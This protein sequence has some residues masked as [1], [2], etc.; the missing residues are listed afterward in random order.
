MDIET[1]PYRK[2]VTAYIVNN[3][4]EFIIVFS[5]QPGRFCKTPAGGVKDGET[6]EQA[7]IREIKE[8]LGIDC[9]IVAKSKINYKWEHQKERI[10]ERQLK[11]R[12]STG[13]IFI[14]K[15]RPETQNIKIQEEEISGYRCIKKEEIDK[16]LSTEE[17][18]EIARKVFDE[19]KDW[20]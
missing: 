13:V 4:K 5:A 1:L 8:E 7:I 16:Y 10:I 3:N 9:E 11:F 12:G 19:F 17:Q 18:K 2:E 15:M 6:E 14:T 20:F